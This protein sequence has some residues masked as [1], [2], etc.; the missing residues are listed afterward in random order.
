MSG[1]RRAGRRRIDGHG[2]G[3]A[4]CCKLSP[5]ASGSGRNLNQ[6]RAGSSRAES[7]SHRAALYAPRR[8]NSAGGV[9]HCVARAR[10]PAPA[11]I[12]SHSETV[13]RDRDCPSAAPASHGT[14]TVS[15]TARARPGSRWH[16]IPWSESVTG[17]LCQCDRRADGP[18]HEGFVVGPPGLILITPKNASIYAVQHCDHAD[19]DCL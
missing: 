3:A 7:D 6:L 11:A 16:R 13:T 4:D 18:G 9:G 2:P 19:R 17:L 1:R 12:P 14:V 15:R 5:I 8:G 10:P